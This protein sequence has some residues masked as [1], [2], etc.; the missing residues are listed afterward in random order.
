[1]N[2]GLE[3]RVAIVT[4]ASRGIGREIALT[5]A[6]YGASIVIGYQKNVA[7]AEE[8]ASQIQ[9]L[10][11]QDR[12]LIVQVEVSRES[13]VKFLFDA[14]ESHFKKKPHILV[15][16]AGVLLSTYP[17][18]EET[19]LEDWD[20]VF[21][22]NTKGCF[23]ACKEAAKRLDDR[24]G[25][26]IVNITSTVVANLPLGYGAYAASK[27]AVETFTKILAKEVGAR[28]I[29]ANCVAPGPVASELFFEGKSEEM[30]QRFVDQTP[31][32]RLGE[33]KDIV[34][35]VALIV[36]DAGEWLNGQVVRLNGGL[37]M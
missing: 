37:A 8:V 11:G 2:R 21:S 10:H 15:N 29:T 35:M 25:G 34:E 33:V 36:S 13:D 23:M 4:G 9:S 20:W 26:R 12:A 17:K 16:A 14:A 28:K 5:L 6:S 19:S 18:L 22:V 7:Q 24:G 1:M 31:L 30:I 32:K 27:A 3:G